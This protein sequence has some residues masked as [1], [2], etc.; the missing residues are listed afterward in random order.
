MN[1]RSLKTLEV[2]PAAFGRLRP[3]LPAGVVAVA[4]S[5]IGG[6]QDAQRY[7][8]QGADVVLVGESLVKDGDPERAVAAMRAIVSAEVKEQG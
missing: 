8:D 2:D 5:G 4:E 6:P 1:A 3:L 7:A